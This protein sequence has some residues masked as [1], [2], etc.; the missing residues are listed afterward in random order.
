V[1]RLNIEHFRKKLAEEKDETKRQTLLHLLAEEEA[2][3]A[4]LEG[5]PKK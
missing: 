2:K 5:L 1:A 4:A 3:L